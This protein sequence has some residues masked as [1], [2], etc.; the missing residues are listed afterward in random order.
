MNNE[1]KILAILENLSEKIDHLENSQSEIKSDMAK[2]K[3]DVS[4]LKEDVSELQET[5]R[6][7][8]IIQENVVLP[9]LDSLA[10]AQKNLRRIL[11]PATKVSE[12]EDEISVIKHVVKSHSTRPA[13]LE[14]AQ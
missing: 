1:E 6:R 12:M 3:T 9:R 11:A 10:D 13:A 2:L 14:K 5:V 7:V 4:G 8:A